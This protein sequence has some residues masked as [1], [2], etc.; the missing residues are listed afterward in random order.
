MKKNLIL[1]LS[2]L[3]ALSSVTAALSVSDK[4]AAPVKDAK[5]SVSKATGANAYTVQEIFANSAKLNKK[6]V[7]IRG[8]VVKVSAGIMGKNWIHIQ[9]GT[10]T[11]AN[12]N[13][14][15]VCTSLDMANV[16]DIVTV[17]GILTKDKDFGSGYKYA[18]IVEES[19]IKK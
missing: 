1:S 13:H 4:A 11:Q 2:C 15:L 19:K 18:A 3:I 12:K 10:G 9:D 8:K 6:N 7:V 5:V 14:N 17:S 16:G